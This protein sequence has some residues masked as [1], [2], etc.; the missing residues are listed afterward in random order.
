MCAYTW[1]VSVVFVDAS[2]HFKSRHQFHLVSCRPISSHNTSCHI[3][4]SHNMSSHAKPCQHMS[5]HVIPCDV[6]PCDAISRHLVSSGVIP[7]GAKQCNRIISVHLGWPDG[8][9]IGMHINM[10]SACVI[11]CLC[12]HVHLR[13]E[14]VCEQV[15]LPA[16]LQRYY[17]CYYE[18]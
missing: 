8:L 15:S 7:S 9:P 4:S 13:S 5:Y 10:L 18:Y 14:S 2:N 1:H 11:G 17:G 6:V 12:M 16:C 3:M